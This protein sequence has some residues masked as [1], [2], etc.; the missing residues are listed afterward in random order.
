MF[1]VTT[2]RLALSHVEQLSRLWVLRVTFVLGYLT[3]W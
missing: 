3:R 1:T 2:L